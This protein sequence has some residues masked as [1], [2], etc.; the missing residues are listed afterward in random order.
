ME[1]S[2]A[3]NNVDLNDTRVQLSDQHEILENITR[4]ASDLFNMTGELHA[5]QVHSCT[6]LNISQMSR[7]AI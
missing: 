4:I 5:E 2:S 6:S 1:Y 3:F 7:V